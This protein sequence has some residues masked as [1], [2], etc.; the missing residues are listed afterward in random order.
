MRV[1]AQETGAEVNTAK[2]CETQLEGELV[3]LNTVG[4]QKHGDKSSTE[5]DSVVKFYR[6]YVISK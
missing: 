2:H 3:N 5:R 4:D 6:L 1:R